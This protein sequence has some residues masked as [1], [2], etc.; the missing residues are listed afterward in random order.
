MASNEE[1][2]EV[3]RKLRRIANKYDGVEALIVERRLGLE[4]DERF[5]AGSVFTSESVK[6]LA[7]LVDPTC[8]VHRDTVECMI[9]KQ[10]AEELGISAGRLSQLVARGQLDSVTIDGKRMITIASVNEHKDNPPAPHR[11][12]K[13]SGK[14]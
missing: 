7:D 10:A 1:R 8:E 14:A 2:R 6:R 4:S 9:F 13:D 3:A 5:I 11:P 12:R